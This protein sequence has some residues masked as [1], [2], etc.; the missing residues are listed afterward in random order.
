MS[1]ID[2]RYTINGLIDTANDGLS[3][4]EQLAN[5]AGCWMTYDTHEGKFAVVMNAPGV[6]QHSFS[7]D[8][9][10]GPITIAATPLDK[11]YNT[12]KVSYPHEDLKGKTDWVQ[13]AI[14][15]ADRLATEFDNVLTLD[16]G[17]VTNPVQAQ[18]L[19]FIELKQSRVDK[20][21]MFK[22]DFSKIGV[23]AGDLIDITND[24][25]GWTSKVFR[26]ISVA[27]ADADDGSIEISIT[28]LEYDA[29]VYDED[30]TRY[31]RSDSSGIIPLS[32]LSAPT[33]PIVTP[34]EGIPN[35]YIT[36]STSII[37][38]LVTEIEFWSSSDVTLADAS[39]S[40]SLLQTYVPS[41]TIPLNSAISI[42][43]S[44]VS[45]STFVVKARAKNSDGVSVFSLPSDTAYYGGT[46]S[47]SDATKIIDPE[48]GGLLSGLGLA[49]LLKLLMQFMGSGTNSMANQIGK[50][51]SD[52]KVITDNLLPVGFM[53]SA[54]SG[55][56]T[57]TAI[58]QGALETIY[59]TTFIAPYTSSY[60]GSVIMDQNSSGAAGG[61]GTDFNEPYDSVQVYVEVID[62]TTSTTIIDES[63]GGFGT[64]YWT[65]WAMALK[66]SL[67]QGRSYTMN[68]YAVVQTASNNT[69]TASITANWN[70]FTVA[71]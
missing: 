18:L 64:N 32:S 19:G 50:A 71:S 60:S 40:Y 57:N 21:V 17:I 47:V 67:V 69:A 58:P 6:S 59:S 41:T 10:I 9:I 37:D 52:P 56:F 8:N 38:G 66:G 26:V 46:T 45:A 20:V 62:N 54:T 53:I 61:R 14:P 23:K 34:V 55:Q 43:V 29:T 5:A 39:R 27:E 35:P 1:T 7:N 68:F 63:S 22:T 24:I 4:L 3:N 48:T 12:V 15:Q 16:Y 2:A 25:Y 42:N 31:V 11:L 30:L 70:L 28:A 65:D 49:S 36:V 44:S 13:V 51:V 33:K